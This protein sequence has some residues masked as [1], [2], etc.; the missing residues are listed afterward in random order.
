MLPTEPD[1]ARAT[2]TASLRWEIDAKG[3][4]V[5]PFRFFRLSLKYL[6]R[7]FRQQLGATEARALS[8]KASNI[9]TLDALADSVKQLFMQ[10]AA[11][12]DSEPVADGQCHLFVDVRVWCSRKA[13]GHLSES[14]R[15][16]R[17]A[18]RST[19]SGTND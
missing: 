3:W 10:R 2:V 11:K 18:T 14:G 6:P 12:S 7:E 4:L 9:G 8:V 19:A 1:T 15:S 16:T 13:S 17:S 5:R